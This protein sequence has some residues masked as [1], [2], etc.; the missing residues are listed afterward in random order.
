[1]RTS[2]PAALAVATAA[3]VALPSTAAA[4]GRELDTR[5]R[6]KGDVLATWSGPGGVSGSVAFAPSREGDLS[7][8]PAAGG[9]SSA[10]FGGGGSPVV[11][12]RRPAAPGTASAAVCVDL[13]Q[14]R[15]MGGGLGFGIAGRGGSLRVQVGEAGPFPGR[16]SFSSGRCPGPTA[17]DLAA[18]LPS[19][20][21]P[22][23]TLRRRAVTLDLGSRRPFRAGEY[24]G[25]VVSTLRFRFGRATPGRRRGRVRVDGPG[26][27]AGDRVAELR[28]GYRV[29]RASGALTTDYRAAGGATCGPLDACGIAGSSVL[30][31]VQLDGRVDFRGFRRLRRGERLPGAGELL[32]AA[33]AGRLAIFG[34]G[35]LR[36]PAT[37]TGQTTRDGT[38]DCRDA[39][40]RAVAFTLAPDRTANASGARLALATGDEERVDLLRSRCA[41]PNADGWENV[42]MSANVG[43]SRRPRGRAAVSRRGPRLARH[44]SRSLE[45]GRFSCSRRACSPS[46]PAERRARSPA[47]RKTALV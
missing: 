41:G 17:G 22:V 47:T 18:A 44:R 3:L 14:A 42:P 25:E 28:I 24:T 13:P 30:S 4:Q 26:P 23:A 38:E 39:A 27:T 37:V 20:S 11:R 15:G 46:Q 31:L 1:M 7:F 40:T 29:A 12:V 34:G 2:S 35:I 19:A 10:G 8:D 5:Y 32:G 36:G 9:I 6:V 33:R 21:L 43:I 45:Q 16:D